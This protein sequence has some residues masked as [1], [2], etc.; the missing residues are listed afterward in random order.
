MDLLEKL[1]SLYL[2]LSIVRQQM[3]DVATFKQESIREQLPVFLH[4]YEGVM[5]EI[6]RTKTQIVV[7]GKNV[8]V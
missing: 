1:N 3:F 5:D 2:D 7:K 4:R 6:T 8:V